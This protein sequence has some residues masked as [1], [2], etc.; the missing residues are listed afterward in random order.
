MENLNEQKEKLEQSEREAGFLELNLR[1]EIREDL[2]QPIKEKL[3]QFESSLEAEASCRIVSKLNRLYRDSLVFP[4]ETKFFLNI[5]TT[6]LTPQQENL[7]N[8]GSKCHIK[9][10][11]D[12]IRKKVECEIL[13]DSLL[14]LEEKNLVNI[15]ENLQLQLLAESTKV[16]DPT[17]SSI[18][19]PEMRAAAKELREHPDIIVR[20]ADKSDVYV[21]MD[22]TAYMEKLQVILDDEQ[23]FEVIT[24][25]PIAEIKTELNKTITNINSSSQQNIFKKVVGDFK[26][27]YIYGT[28]KT[29]KSGYPVRPIISQIPTPVYETAKTLN[30]ILTPYLPAEFQINST[31]DFL[32]ILRSTQLQ[33]TLASLDVESLF[34]NVPVRET[35][36]IICRNAYNHPTLPKPPF[37]EEDLKKLLLLCTTR[38]PFTNS[39]GRMYLQRD[40]VSMGSPLGVLFANY[41]MTHVENAVFAEQPDLK[42]LVYCRYIDDSFLL[43]SNEDELP[44]IISAFRAN[45]SLNFTYEIG[46]NNRI[47]FLDVTIDQSQGTLHTSVYRKPTNPGIY[48][49]PNSECPAR[50]KEGTIKALIHRT[51]KISS[52]FSSFRTGIIRQNQTS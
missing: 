37:N 15:N 38:C 12:P 28:V 33:G 44:R 7:L 27:G 47:N 14:K 32:T 22:K 9:Q 25:N 16:R 21:V 10:K 3:N 8:M 40:G 34:T 17:M 29:H 18:Y 46:Q 19:T 52:Y 4:Q 31:D 2:W 50:Y 36:E 30:T 6:T 51:F 13:Y 43:L 42:P 23:K 1:E 26:P 45:S 39:D 48:L 20:K 5:S 24:R 35:I 11:I 49:N 41:Y